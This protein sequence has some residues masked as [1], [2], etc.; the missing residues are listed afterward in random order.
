MSG[1]E[2]ISG[3]CLCGQITFSCMNSFFTFHLCHC[4]QCQKASGSAHVSNLF[5]DT[6]NIVWESGESLVRRYDLPGQTISVAFCEN[7]GTP[8]PYVSKSD[9]ALIVPAGSLDGE[10]SIE[11]Q[12]HIFWS[13]R[14][15]WYERGVAAKKYAKF[16]E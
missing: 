16:P 3:S 7:C 6:G 12:D 10:P 15:A 5:T 8:V 4:S 14:A 9:K 13:E 2:Q 1:D 11:P